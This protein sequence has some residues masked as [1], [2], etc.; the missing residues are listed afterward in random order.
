MFMDGQTDSVAASVG[1]AKALSPAFAIRGAHLSITQRLA[2]EHVVRIHTSL[3]TW[4]VKRIA[5]YETSGNKKKKADSIEF[6]RVLHAL[7]ATIDSR[8]AAQM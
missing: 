1:L 2:S 6:F 5:G 7:L 8:E 3:L 4:A